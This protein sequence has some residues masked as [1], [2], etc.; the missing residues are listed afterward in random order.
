[1]NVPETL[2]RDDGVTEKFSRKENEKDSND[3]KQESGCTSAGAADAHGPGPEIDPKVN[4]PSSSHEST[5][6]KAA[7]QTMALNVA[8]EALEHVRQANIAVEFGKEIP[9]TQCIPCLR[10]QQQTETQPVGRFGFRQTFHQGHFRSAQACLTCG[11]PVCN[12]HRCPDFARENVVICNDCVRFFSLDFVA[13]AAEQTPEERRRLMNHMLDVYDRAWLILKYSS[14]FME[15]ISTTLEESSKSKDKYSLGSSATGFVGGLVGVAGALTI[16]TPA[17]V[18]LLL[19]SVVF[20]SA[21]AAT[22]A[23]SEAMFNRSSANKAADT[24][25]TVHGMLKSLARLSQQYCLEQAAAAQ[26]AAADET[27]EN[28]AGDDTGNT[29][30]SQEETK[31]PDQRRPNSE[32][33]NSSRKNWIRATSTVIRP[34]TF[35]VLSAASV[36]M[37][38]REM[39]TTVDKIRNGSPCSKANNVKNIAQDVDLFPTTHDLAK[40]CV[41]YFQ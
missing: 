16:W 13:N 20:G 28:D 35:G 3:A 22:S 41:H 24:I 5:Q 2:S 10:Q 8:Y 37:E 26:Y 29:P 23:G 7:Q 21:G 27:Q 6:E 18:P 30:G 38:A 15:E 11:Y 32:F 14:Q 12:Q 17:G 19:A 36:V 25:I 1:M 4:T 9:V 39:K 33:Q 34:L 40:E 31:Q